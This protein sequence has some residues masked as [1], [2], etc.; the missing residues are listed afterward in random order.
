MCNHLK[1]SFEEKTNETDNSD[2]VE[3]IP[4]KGFLSSWAMPTAIYPNVASF[5]A[6]LRGAG[7]R[8]IWD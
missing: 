4:I 1:P 7:H 8:L 3:P 2:D 6:P 5:S